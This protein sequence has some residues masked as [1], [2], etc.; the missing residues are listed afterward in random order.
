MD[1]FQLTK[2]KTRQKILELF[3]SDPLKAYYL[4]D[5]ERTLTISA[6][7]IRREL[8]SLV[9]AGFFKSVRKGRLVYYKINTSSGLYK[10][11]KNLIYNHKPMDIQRS[12]YWWTATKKPKEL[13]DDIYCQTRDVFTARLES[14]ISKLEKTLGDKAY[15]LVAVAGEIG[16]NSFDH[17]LGNWP[18]MPGIF[19]ALDLRQKIIVLADR[20]QGILKTLR[21]VKPDITDDCQALNVAFTQIISGRLSEKR[22]NGLKFVAK[23][24][25]EKNWSL[26]FDSGIASLEI[27]NKKLTIRKDRQVVHGCFAV[28]RY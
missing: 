18:D 19:F 4:R 22:G 15:L 3:L 28:I 1:I 27:K 11:I 13:P 21:N 24:I 14:I 20:G 23:I 8:I 2:S 26:R 25:R 5:L 9:N 17:N 7:N 10:I 6:G 12:G 16:N